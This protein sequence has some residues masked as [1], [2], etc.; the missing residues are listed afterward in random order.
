VFVQRVGP[1]VEVEAIFRDARG[2]WIDVG[3][4]L[5]LN[6]VP[7]ELLRRSNS[8][9]R[10]RSLRWT[11]PQLADRGRGVGDAAKYGHSGGGIDDSFEGASVDLDAWRR[12]AMDYTEET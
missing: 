5:V 9:P 7:P 6:A 1:D 4:G 12:S 3:I 11:P 8:T 2:E 10:L